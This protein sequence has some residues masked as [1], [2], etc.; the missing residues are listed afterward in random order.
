[1]AHPRDSGHSASSYRPSQ[2]L[3]ES[4]TTSPRIVTPS[5]MRPPVP[6]PWSTCSD[7][8]SFTRQSDHPTSGARPTTGR[9]PTRRTPCS[10]WPGTV[11]AQ[12]YPRVWVRGRPAY[13]HRVAYER[14]HSRLRPGERVY[15]TCGNRACMRVSHMTM[16]PPARKGRRPGTAKLSARRVRAI[17]A[18][19]ARPDRPTQAALAQRYGVSRSAISL[20]VRGVTWSDV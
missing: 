12:G 2:Q 16:E 9:R 17:R 19:W 6:P 18:A 5:P 13:A 8:P 11:D 20:V 10:P 3:L 15:R 14:V 4:P 7:P 1:M